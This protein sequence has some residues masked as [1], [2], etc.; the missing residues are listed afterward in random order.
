MPHSVMCSNEVHDH[1]YPGARRHRNLTEQYIFYGS[2]APQRTNATSF[3]TNDQSP[4]NIDSVSSQLDQHFAFVI[5]EVFKHHNQTAIGN[6]PRVFKSCGFCFHFSSRVDIFTE[7][8]SQSKKLSD[9]PTDGG[10]LEKSYDRRSVQLF[11][12]ISFV[13]VA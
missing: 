1:G 3:P 6:H 12:A 13:V 4:W 11:T 5:G 7:A 10:V 8:L 9:R 2:D